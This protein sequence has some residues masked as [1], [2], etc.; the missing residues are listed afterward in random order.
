MKYFLN[1]KN[2]KK[3]G[4]TT[5]YIVCHLCRKTVHINTK[6]DV[7]PDFFDITKGIIKGKSKEVKDDNLILNNC[8]SLITD[9]FVRYRLQ[10]KQLTPDLLK[11]EYI[12]PSYVIDFYLFFENEINN[13]YKNQDITA[14]TKRHHL[15]VLS[16]MKRWKKNL[17]F[18]EITPSLI[19]SYSGYSRRVLKNNQNTIQSNL[20]RWKSYLNIAIQNGIIDRNPFDL[21]TIKSEK[22]SRVFL[23]ENELK[24]LV[25]EYKKPT[26]TKDFELRT[27]RHFLFMC[28]TGLRISD[29]KNLKQSNI[30]NDC[31]YFVPIKTRNAKKEI[32]CIQL[33]PLARRLI[34]DEEPKTT[35]VFNSISEQKMNE[36][37]KV[38]A[39][40]MD[41]FK[42]IS[43]HSARH[44]FATLFIEKTNDV[45]SLQRLLGHSRIEETMIYVHVSNEKTNAQMLN[46]SKL[47][48]L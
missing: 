46:F 5:V 19:N 32:L 16:K 20:K 17:A 25:K 36:Q 35:N 21:V 26:K 23:T 48:G 37:I 9:I 8:E 28:C 27:L 10:N 30:K 38:I 31:I 1:P 33:T 4:K 42:N 45:A 34:K 22:T 40:N 13:R 14:G 47:L 43:N 15:G 18:S 24:I 39:N 6:V 12:N 44:T 11:S 29:F 41:I 2:V 7:D 3:N